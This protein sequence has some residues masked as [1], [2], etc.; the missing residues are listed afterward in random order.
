MYRCMN[1][2]FPEG[3]MEQATELIHSFNNGTSDKNEREILRAIEELGITD[4]GDLF[5]LSRLAKQ[6][7]VVRDGLS[8]FAQVSS[9]FYN[10]F[11]NSQSFSR[12]L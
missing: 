4:S 3:K 6:G 8:A 10:G 2:G 9:L 1:G 11:K 12:I 5:L 7:S